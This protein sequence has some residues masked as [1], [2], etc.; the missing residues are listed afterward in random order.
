MDLQKLY[1]Y[2]RQAVQR[3]ELIQD[4]DR[5]AVGIS[6]GKDSLALLYALA[7]LRKFYPKKFELVAITVDL[8]LGMDFS[9]V[10]ALCESLEV[11][12][13][14]VRTEI[15]EIV[16]KRSTEG[17]SCSLCSKMR[18]GALNEQA[19]ALG[20]NK[21]AY[22]HHMDDI[23]DTLVMN[24]K[25]EGRI[26]SF[27]PYT[28]LEQSDLVL[29]RPFIYIPEY[30][31]LSFSSKYH[32]PVVK[33]LCPADGITK[34]TEI[35]DYLASLYQNDRQLRKHLFTA[36]ENSEINDWVISRKEAAKYE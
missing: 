20:C 13:T 30:E 29:I 24:L 25:Y 6:G 36:V 15:A 27:A 18:K 34:R 17:Y 12:Y 14:I 31:I 33:N 2:T 8:G 22:A 3:Y 7:G 1:S 35:H 9:A 4:Q 11:P 28:Y 16:S 5:I 23:V 32:L 26:Y 21:I 10:S 19:K